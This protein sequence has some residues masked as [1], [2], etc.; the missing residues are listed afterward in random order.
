MQC[1]VGIPDVAA[2][3][4]LSGQSVAANPDIEKMPDAGRKPLAVQ[5]QQ[6]AKTRFQG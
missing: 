2:V 4:V 5:Q 1:A 3:F 6:S